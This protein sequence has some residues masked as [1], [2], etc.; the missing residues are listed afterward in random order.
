MVTYFVSLIIHPLKFVTEVLPTCEMQLEL[1]SPH[2]NWWRLWLPWLSHV[3]TK[4]PSNEYGPT[5]VSCILTLGYLGIA[6]DTLGGGPDRDTLGGF[7]W[8]RHDPP[9]F[10]SACQMLY[11][12]IKSWSLP[13]TADR[14][15]A[16]F[17]L[18]PQGDGPGCRHD[19]H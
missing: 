6:W 5:S 7:R 11:R 10:A 14:N 18:E 15:R 16:T 17:P 19:W 1:R 4:L 3:P 9:I 8:T 2:R 13:G 12:V